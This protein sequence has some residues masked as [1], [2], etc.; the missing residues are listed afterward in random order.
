MQ[1][2]WDEETRKKK[3]IFLVLCGSY[4]SFMEKEVLGSKSPL[5]GRRTGQIAL[6]P[7]D[8]EDIK[9]FYPLYAPRVL[10][11]VYSVLGGTPAYLIRFNGK[12]TL[13]SNIKN[14][15]LNKNSFL[16]SEP[17]FLLMEE[18]REPS[19]Y[20]SILKS[21]A[22]GKT[23]LNE[24]VQETG[25]QDSQKVNKYISNLRDLRI[26]LRQVPITEDKPHK[27]RKGLYL[28]QDPFFRFWFRFIYPNLSYL[29]EDDIDFVWK[30]KIKP[31]LDSF[32]SFVFEDICINK[33]KK[34]NRN[35]KLPFKAKNIG[36]WWDKED[37][38]DIVAFDDQNSFLFC[39]C[40]WTKKKM[41]AN[42]FINLQRKTERFPQAAKKYYGFFSKT[43]FTQ[44]LV[45]AAKKSRDIFL[46]DYMR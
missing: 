26:V 39:E 27:S 14:E 23:K 36:R 24:I 29:E 15:I 17:R 9:S 30:E 2:I 31:N 42:I 41:G 32:T 45:D 7:L 3:D 34:L 21:I 11:Q 28:I 43:G 44:E 22:F 37:E 4:M 10:A 1:K 6:Q 38:I 16:Y 40:R 20:F 5:Y 35:N 18:L 19:V 33:L 8:F 46:F 13:E 12:K 25:L